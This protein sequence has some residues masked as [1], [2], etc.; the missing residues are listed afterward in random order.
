M[1]NRQTVKI[2]NYQVDFIIKTR[3]II[4]IGSKFNWLK[5]IN[6]KL[7]PKLFSLTIS[8]KK[9]NFVALSMRSSLASVFVMLSVLV[10]AW[11]RNIFWKCR[12]M[13]KSRK[14]GS[15]HVT[16]V[17]YNI[18]VKVIASFSNNALLSFN[19]LLLQMII[20]ALEHALHTRSRFNCF[21]LL[22]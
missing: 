21:R 17:E 8:L 4:Q 13:R 6:F 15:M 22:Y 12:R 20:F 1:L 18:F 3:I 9:K 16:C 10:T 19:R 2:L 5:L 14:V 7:I 11:K